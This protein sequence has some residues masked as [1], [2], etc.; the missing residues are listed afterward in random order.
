MQ[1]T[2]PRAQLV[3][4]RHRPLSGLYQLLFFSRRTWS[5][6]DQNLPNYCAA[7]LP[8]S[9]TG[10]TGFAPGDPVA[11]LSYGSFSEY[12]VEPARTAMAVPWVGPEVVALL[13]SGLTAS[14]GLEQAGR[15][16]AG[17]T[18]LV[19]AAA[20]GTGGA[21]GVCKNAEHVP[22]FTICRHG[23]S[24]HR[25]DITACYRLVAGDRYVGMAV[26]GG[27]FSLATTTCM[28]RACSHNSRSGTSMRDHTCVPTPPQRPDQLLANTY[29]ALPVPMPALLAGQFVVQLAKAAGC[30]VIATCGG[31]DKAKLL[32]VRG[33]A[34]GPTGWRRGHGFAAAPS[35][36]VCTR[37][38]EICMLHLEHQGAQRQLSAGRHPCGSPLH[39]DPPH[40]PHPTRRVA[41]K[42]LTTLLYQKQCADGVIGFRAEGTARRHANPHCV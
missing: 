20:G 19:T 35:A 38:R 4:L 36:P 27:A 11:C 7:T 1:S 34:V 15:I 14:I 9:G 28:Q 30:H 16:A 29:P 42:L 40:L 8:L 26:D 13:T 6:I 22:R 24:Q 18:V 31:P 23:I 32:K 17:E 39:A 21:V 3:I 5:H 37:S 12:G 25:H 10:V 41:Q 33:V 2:V